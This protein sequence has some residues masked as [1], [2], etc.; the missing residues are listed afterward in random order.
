MEDVVVKGKGKGQVVGVASVLGGTEIVLAHGISESERWEPLTLTSSEDPSAD[1][2]PRIVGHVLLS[3]SVRLHGE[4]PPSMRMPLPQT[5]SRACSFSHSHT[6]S[7][8]PPA[9]HPAHAPPLAASLPHKA[10]GRSFLGVGGMG[11]SFSSQ[12]A[13]A[14]LG[15][16][17]GGSFSSQRPS[18]M[19]GGMGGSFTTRRAP[20]ILGG[21]MGGSFTSRPPLAPARRF[22]HTGG[23][24]TSALPLPSTALFSG[25]AFGESTGALPLQPRMFSEPLRE[26][27]ASF[28]GSVDG[29]GG[30][31]EGE[32]GG[33]GGGADEHLED[34]AEALEGRV[35]K[36]LARALAV[37]ES[38]AAART[39]TL[40]TGSRPHSKLERP[41]LAN[42]NMS[43]RHP[44]PLRTGASRGGARG[45]ARYATARAGPLVS[46]RWHQDFWDLTQDEVD[47]LDWHPP[48]AW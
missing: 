7:H 42:S 33:G 6:S 39:A 44:P 11:G 4:P 17:L 41:S 28:A 22:L 48:L 24:S 27:V 9:S 20:A 19:A 15:G 1:G 25:G 36:T 40:V 45:A 23:V 37:L 26:E 2:E 35:P 3:V 46:E 29:E 32:E 8:P 38:A 5:L 47:E 12:R 14:S 30:E 21:G 31:V 13:S 18:A 43:V 34:L 16:G 10:P